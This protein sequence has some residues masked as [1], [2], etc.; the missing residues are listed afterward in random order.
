MV[1]V[2]VELEVVVIL[3]SVLLERNQ[4][5]PTLALR[6]S[7]V[8]GKCSV[9]RDAVGMTRIPQGFM[10]SNSGQRRILFCQPAIRFIFILERRVAAVAAATLPSGAGATQITTPASMLSRLTGVV[11]Q[12]M[13]GTDNAEMS[14]FLGDFRSALG[15]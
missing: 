9:I 2:D 8:L 5:A 4:R 12:Y 14:A 1:A 10:L 15:N 11:D 13:T 7:T 3:M 6:R